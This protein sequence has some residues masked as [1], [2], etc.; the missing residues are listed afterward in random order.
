VVNALEREAPVEGVA[1]H[2]TV[3]VPRQTTWLCC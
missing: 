1:N 3:P 2:A